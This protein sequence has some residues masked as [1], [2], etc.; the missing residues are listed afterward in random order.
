MAY[1][2]RAM[3]LTNIMIARSKK[4]LGK[5]FFSKL[6]EI[7]KNDVSQNQTMPLTYEVITFRAI[8]HKK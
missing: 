6:E 8:N 1:D 2:L 5:H 7:Y 4:Y 3:S